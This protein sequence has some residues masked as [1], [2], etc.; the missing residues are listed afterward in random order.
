VI[1]EVELESQ[2][3]AMR[4][5]YY[6]LVMQVFIKSGKGLLLY[7]AQVAIVCDSAP[8]AHPNTA[9]SSATSWISVQLK[10]VDLPNNIV[11]SAFRAKNELRPMVE[12]LGGLVAATLLTN[13]PWR[14]VLI[15]VPR[16]N[17]WYFIGLYCT[18]L[19]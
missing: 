3:S 19:H 16:L 18:A 9:R 17:G 10:P 15:P 1:E 4:S 2:Y 14:A 12:A 6:F 7:A 13:V 11:S 8:R 5:P